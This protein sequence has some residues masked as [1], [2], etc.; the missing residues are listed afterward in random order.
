MNDAH[1]SAAAL[2]E[3]Q[4]GVISR[5]QALEQGMSR[6]A[7]AALVT[8]GTW[9]PMYRAVFRLA[10]SERTLEQTLTAACLAAG[11]GAVA[12]HRSAAY[13][14]G[15]PG[16]P[17]WVEVTVPLPG[18]RRVEGLLMHRSRL[19]PADY[20]GANG[21]PVTSVARTLIDLAG[22]VGEERLARLLDH[23]LVNRLVRRAELAERAGALGRAGRKGAGV[24]GALL[25]A[26]PE[27]QRPMGSEFEGKLF[28]ALKAARLPLPIPQYR[29][30]VPGGHERF[31]DFAYP[32]VRL[33][34]EADSYLWHAS[35]EAWEKERERNNDLV[36]LGWSFLPLTWDTVRYFPAE[37]AR[38]VR[39]SLQA[40]R[41]G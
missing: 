6:H 1:R 22:C 27:S 12:S 34:I 23:A 3:V 4:H 18:Q 30:V 29:V 17:R 7:V 2:A 32:E 24:L 31:L 5:W 15:L 21:I 19:E 9:E 25:E 14:F 13:L 33:A 26:R 40:R 20:T 16:V 37:A 8:G 28:R 41:A 35:R 36:A 10:G 39:D 38:Q 11:P